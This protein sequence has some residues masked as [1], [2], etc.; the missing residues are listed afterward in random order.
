MTCT[1]RTGEGNG[2]DNM[3]K[4][5]VLM[6][7]APGSGKSTFIRELGLEY[8]SISPDNLR[9]LLSEPKEE[10]VDN[11]ISI[12]FSRAIRDACTFMTVYVTCR[13]K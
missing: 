10:N 6:H 8:L 7:G 12:H 2:E 13:N 5:L 9:L 3:S 1:E 11:H 4:R